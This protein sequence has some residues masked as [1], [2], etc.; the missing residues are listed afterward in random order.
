MKS[1]SRLRLTDLSTLSLSLSLSRSRSRSRFLAIALTHCVEDRFNLERRESRVSFL[2]PRDNAN[3]VRTREAVAGHL[4]MAT[5]R[6]GRRNF[7]AR[8]DKFDYL[9]IAITEIKGLGARSL[10]YRHD[11]RGED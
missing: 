2:Y 9:P 3:H 6:P 10:H 1:S 8:G 5:S 4:P 7:N 11:R